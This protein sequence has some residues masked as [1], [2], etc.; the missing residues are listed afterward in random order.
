MIKKAVIIVSIILLA[1]VAY[2]AW[3][4]FYLNSLTHGDCV[5][6]ETGKMFTC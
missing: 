6:L 1:I 5:D 4:Y 3:D 2:E